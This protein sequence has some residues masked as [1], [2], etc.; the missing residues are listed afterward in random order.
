MVRARAETAACVFA[1]VDDL[2]LAEV[3]SV[4]GDLIGGQ[5]NLEVPG[6]DGGGTASCAERVQQ[7]ERIG[8]ESDKAFFPFQGDVED[9]A[10]VLE[11]FLEKWHV[12]PAFAQEGGESLGFVERERMRR[13]IPPEHGQQFFEVAR[14][15][16]EH[17]KAR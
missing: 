2:H 11:D 7:R 17:D 10:I 12:G 6:G 14:S 3:A 5:A 4:G 13:M 9:G 8:A 15:A 1:S 16:L